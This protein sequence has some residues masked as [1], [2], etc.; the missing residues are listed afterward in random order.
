MNRFLKSRQLDDAQRQAIAAALENLQVGDAEGRRIF[1]FA[2]DY[3]LTEYSN[4]LASRPP[5]ASDEAIASGAALA[6]L[7]TQLQTVTLQV[8][9]LSSRHRSQLFDRMK[10]C[11]D[12]HRSYDHDYLEALL[13]E[14]SRLQ[15]ACHDVSKSSKHSDRA[16]DSRPEG[17]FVGMLAKAYAECFEAAPDADSSGL[18]ASLL[19]SIGEQVGLDLDFD[20][21]SLELLLR[22]D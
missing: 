3:E 10:V 6:Q 21:A 11:D 5:P 14:L 22:S 4:Y 2:L 1:V 18:F 17:R 8:R 12:Y 9:N 16:A 15:A 13:A 7:E 20:D 19:S